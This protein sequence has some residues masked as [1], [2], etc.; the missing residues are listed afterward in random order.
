MLVLVI[1]FAEYLFLILLVEF[2]GRVKCYIWVTNA[3][4]LNKIVYVKII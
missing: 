4:Q 2:I 3:I 1:V